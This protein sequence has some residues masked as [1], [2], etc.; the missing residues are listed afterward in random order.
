MSKLKKSFQN[1]IHGIALASKERVFR[2]LLFC[3]VVVFFALFYFP[4][5]IT[6]KTIIILTTILVL[7]LELI[8]SQIERVL[9]ILRPDYSEEVRKIKDISAGAVLLFC[10]AAAVI[11]I[12]IFLPYILAI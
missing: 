8:N 3:A 4:L 9:D 2:I 5:T 7:S 12:L 6:E 10:L 1:A 11:G